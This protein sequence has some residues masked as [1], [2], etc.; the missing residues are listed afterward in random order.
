MAKQPDAMGLEVTG[1]VKDFPGVRALDHVDFDALPG[2]I[3][4]IVGANGA[5][6]STL[7]KILAGIY[8]KDQGKMFLEGCEVSL[9][10]PLDAKE[11]GIAMSPQEIDSALIPNLSIGENIMLDHI[12]RQKAQLVDWADIHEQAGRYADEVGL[13]VDTRD[14][15]GELSISQR[16][17][18]IIAQALASNAKFIILDE[19]TASLSLREVKELFNLLRELIK[20]YHLSLIY[21]S[22]R[23]PEVFEIADRI[24]IMR[25]GRKIRTVAPQETSIDEV[26]MLMLNKEK[27]SRSRIPRANPP[28]PHSPVLLKAEGLKRGR[29]VNDHYFELHEGE[30]IAIIGLVGA[31]KTE[32][33]R[34]LFGA[35]HL[36]G[37]RLVIRDQAVHIVHPSDAVK[38]GIFLVPEDRRRQ[39]VLVE[40]PI[41]QNISLPNLAD[42]SGNGFINTRKEKYAANDMIR[43]LDIKCEDNAQVVNY[44]SGGNQQKVAIGKWLVSS[45]QVLLFDEPTKG[46]DVG[47]KEDIFKIIAGLADEGAGV[48]YFSSELDEAFRISDRVLVMYD[49]R[50]VADLQTEKTNEEELLLYASGGG[51]QE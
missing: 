29:L 5:G 3:H 31:G 47:A 15:V 22:H 45:G 26:V 44:L 40:F 2:E 46:V 30:I 42:F 27:A 11:H 28:G 20:K 6:K 48:I 33:A 4:A 21:I 41:F 35:D 13:Q 50:I 19:P 10:N 25:D 43:R 51:K 1:L 49:G 36:D 8:H 14:M 18:V 24:T 12:A 32:L 7:C 39:G 37:G 34:V 9:E 17:K 16:Q 23:M 38:Q